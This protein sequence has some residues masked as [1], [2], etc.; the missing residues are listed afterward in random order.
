MESIDYYLIIPMV[1][2][3]LPICSILK[4]LTCCFD[5]KKKMQTAEAHRLVGGLL[6]LLD[7]PNSLP[8]PQETVSPS[9]VRSS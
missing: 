3:R 9:A 8:K 6:G 4:M 7:A 1:P 2:N 5:I